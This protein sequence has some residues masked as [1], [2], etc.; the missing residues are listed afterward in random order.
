MSMAL[1]VASEFDALATLD[2]TR[3][4]VSARLDPK[5]RT[6]LGQFFTPMVTARLMASM[7]TNESTTLRVL[8]AGAGIGLLT[9]A[10]IAEVCRREKRPER[11]S[12]VAFEIDPALSPQLEETHALCRALCGSRNYI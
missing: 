6:K 5:Q 3:V 2:L 1:A 4:D 12:V 11:I 9:A 10:F 7:F 8:D